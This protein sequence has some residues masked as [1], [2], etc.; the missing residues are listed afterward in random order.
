MKHEVNIYRESKS[1][2]TISRLWH[3][4]VGTIL[5]TQKL[6]G[7][8]LAKYRDKD[9][10]DEISWWVLH[11]RIASP[12]VEVVVIARN[13]YQETF[14]GKH[15]TGYPFP[16]GGMYI[17]AINKANSE[18]MVQANHF[19]R[20]TFACT[21]RWLDGTRW[22]LRHVRKKGDMTASIRTDLFRH[23]LMWSGLIDPTESYG[24][25]SHSGSPEVARHI[26]AHCEF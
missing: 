10:P 23:L 20:N 8:T 22:M 18:L 3:E 15:E 13:D 19:H 11:P 9:R 1:I 21:F 17:N 25:P 24:I 2:R 14:E 6:H 26:L 12:I 5:E 4:P 16:P 7:V